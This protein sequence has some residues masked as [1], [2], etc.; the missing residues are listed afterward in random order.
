MGA[1]GYISPRLEPVK[2]HG[3]IHPK[4]DHEIDPAL[5]EQVARV[6]VDDAAPCLA[7]L[8]DGVQQLS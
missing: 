4:H 1:G 6:P 2:M 3:G 8:L 7:L 5:G